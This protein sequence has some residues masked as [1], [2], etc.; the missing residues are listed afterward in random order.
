MIST[1]GPGELHSY[2]TTVADVGGVTYTELTEALKEQATDDLGGAWKNPV[3]VLAEKE[4]LR[5]K[6]WRN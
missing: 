3:E 6:A 1:L 5:A 4:T 2:L